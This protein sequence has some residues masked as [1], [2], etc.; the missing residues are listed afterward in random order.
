VRY[1]AAAPG[2]QPWERDGGFDVMDREEIRAKIQEL[3][4]EV[5]DDE[6]VVLSDETTADDVDGWD[7]TNHVRLMVALEAAFNIRFETD[8]IVAPETVGE[9]ISLIQ[10]KL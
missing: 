1:P 5:V 2:L 9:L 6:T 4:R 7:S 8:E 3:L 10:S